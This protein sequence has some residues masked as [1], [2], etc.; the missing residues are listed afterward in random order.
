METL[1]GP[2]TTVLIVQRPGALCQHT[3]LIRAA[4]LVAVAVLGALV[5]VM[6]G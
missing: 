5:A 1:A 2:R 3:K 6:V 4:Q